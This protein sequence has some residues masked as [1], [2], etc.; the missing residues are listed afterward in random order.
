ML[1]IIFP[2]IFIIIFLFIYNIQKF[3]NESPLNMFF[4]K[5]YVIALEDRKKRLEK[6]LSKINLKYEYIEPIYK[7]DLNRKELIKTNIITP[8][9]NYQKN[10]G[11]IACH[12]SHLKTIKTFLNTSAQNCLILEDDINDIDLVD[13]NSR[14]KNI[15]N[16]IKTKANDY[17]IIYFG[18]CFDNCK[19]NKYITDNISKTFGTACRHAYAL[20]KNGARI[21]SENTLPLTAIFSKSKGDE[22]YKHLIKNKKLIAYSI[23][24]SLFQ[25]NRKNIN[26]TLGNYQELRE[27]L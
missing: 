12:Q 16:D 3:T 25:Q 21:I 23:T 22:Y 11:R 5:V 9:Y 1:L 8:R 26:T 14:I 18:R 10:M 4:D 27:C 7:K 6:V 2:L 19:K 20:S 13:F 24:P 17:D 15:L